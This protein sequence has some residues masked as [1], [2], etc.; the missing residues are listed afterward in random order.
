ME[1]WSN[2]KKQEPGI[3]EINCLERCDQLLRFDL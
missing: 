3:S 2:E 1:W